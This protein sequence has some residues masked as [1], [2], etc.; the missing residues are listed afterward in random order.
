MKRWLRGVRFGEAPTYKII[1]EA[2]EVTYKLFGSRRDQQ[3]IVK[4]IF[5]QLDFCPRKWAWKVDMRMPD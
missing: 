2:T 1:D 3:T 4:F 5:L